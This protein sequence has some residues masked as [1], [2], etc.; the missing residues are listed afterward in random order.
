VA[1]VLPENKT[2]CM[3]VLL[4][5]LLV[6]V[7]GVALLGALAGFGFFSPCPRGKGFPLFQLFAKAA[8]WAWLL[9]LIYLGFNP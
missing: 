9:G 6:I 1:V 8:V 2:A 7:S 5:A 3:P 4:Y